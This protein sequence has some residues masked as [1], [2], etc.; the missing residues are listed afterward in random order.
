[1]IYPFNASQYYW[2]VAHYDRQR[3]H[4]W[5][6]DRGHW[7][8]LYRRNKTHDF[9]IQCGAPLIHAEYELLCWCRRTKG[10]PN[11]WHAVTTTTQK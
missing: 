6:T 5:E 1:M 11:Q 4:I 7:V 8:Q 10:K 2:H 3:F 9:Y